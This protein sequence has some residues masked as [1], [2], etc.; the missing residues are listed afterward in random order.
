[1]HDQNNQNLILNEHEMNGFENGNNFKT[2]THFLVFSYWILT[3]KQFRALILVI[4]SG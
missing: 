3:Q 2:C 4:L 1:M